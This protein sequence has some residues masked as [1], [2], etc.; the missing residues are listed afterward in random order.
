M[1]ST[2]GN[3]RAFRREW[4]EQGLNCSAQHGARLDRASLQMLLLL[5]FATTVAVPSVAK[6]HAEPFKV[7]GN[8]EL[9][10]DA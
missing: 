10:Q 6:S 9:K 5:V 2:L 1:L 8:G 3:L 4:A 7:E